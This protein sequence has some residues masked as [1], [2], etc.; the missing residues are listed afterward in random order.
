MSLENYE[1]IAPSLFVARTQAGFN[2][3]L[4]MHQDGTDMPVDGFPVSYPSF[5]TIHLG[6]RGHHYLDVTCWPV[7]LVAD[8]CKRHTPEPVHETPE[9]EGARMYRENVSLSN[10][11]GSVSPVNFPHVGRVLDAYVVEAENDKAN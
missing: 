3:I 7:N 2:Q 11:W 9:E 6:Y 10:V 8:A 1:Y 5:V 4:K